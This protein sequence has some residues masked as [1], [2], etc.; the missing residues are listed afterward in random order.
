MKGDLTMSE[1][2]DVP[3]DEIPYYLRM[4]LEGLPVISEEDAIAAGMDAG[5]EDGS[6]PPLTYPTNPYDTSF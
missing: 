1:F 6:Y 5:Y 2:F 4:Q 3:D